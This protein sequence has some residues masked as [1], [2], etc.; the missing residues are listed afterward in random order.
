MTEPARA[1]LLAIPFLVLS[2][3]GARE[4][5][6][7]A[8]D[9]LPPATQPS[10]E[11]RRA[12]EAVTKH[13]NLRLSNDRRSMA[14]KFNFRCHFRPP[15]GARTQPA[16]VVVVRDGAQIGLLVVGKDGLPY[17][18]VTDGL[19]AAVDAE[20]PGGLVMHQGGSVSFKVHGEAGASNVEFRYA[21]ALRDSTIVMD[22]AA[23]LSEILE[24]VVV[25]RFNAERR[26][27]EIRTVRG[28]R[29]VLKLAERKA[30]YPVELLLI[31]S[32]EGVGMAV[33]E[34]AVGAVPKAR[35]AGR[36]AADVKNL[37]VPVRELTDADLKGFKILPPKAFGER[38]EE[39]AA[40]KAFRGLFPT[41]HP[42][43]EPG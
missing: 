5:E 7:R 18:Y 28:A 22:P 16:D 31:Q 8:A 26:E 40:A 32:G 17:C 23:A 15:A 35:L 42:A 2:L 3:A 37:G 39:R 11:V 1:S 12:V 14:E 36:S 21:S 10:A 25:G 24:K 19:L 20:Q 33:G 29:V 43:A 30:A 38:E 41:T 4:A 13:E 27:A 9:A 6:E 34:V